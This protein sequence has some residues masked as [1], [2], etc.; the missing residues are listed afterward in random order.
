M[1][2]NRPTHEKSSHICWRRK[3]L[4]NTDRAGHLAATHADDSGQ[5]SGMTARGNCSSAPS[6]SSPAGSTSTIST[7]TPPG[8]R[9]E[10]AHNGKSSNVSIPVQPNFPSELFVLFAVSGKRM[11]LD[12][13][14]VN[15]QAQPTDQSF[16]IELLRKYRRFRGFWRCWLSLWTMNHCDFVRVS[17]ISI[18]FSS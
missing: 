5:A 3:Y 15:V 18:R 16:F 13:E 12:L 4:F 11:T 9:A 10:G 17:V 2:V 1:L 6:G 8:A 14:N 7:L